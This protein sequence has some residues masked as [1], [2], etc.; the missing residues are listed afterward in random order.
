MAF[1]PA[2]KRILQKLTPDMTFDTLSRTLADIGG[3]LLVH[4]L[5]EILD[6]TVRSRVAVH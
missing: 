3:Q 6:N 4:T 5:R 2:L 1:C